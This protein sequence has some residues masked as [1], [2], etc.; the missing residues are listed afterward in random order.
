MEFYMWH[1]FFSHT[2]FLSFQKS[3]ILDYFLTQ[4]KKIRENFL[5]SAQI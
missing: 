3:Q 4:N 5:I 1:V 2:W